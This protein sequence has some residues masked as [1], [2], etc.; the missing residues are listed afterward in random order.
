M[1]AA[2]ISR[3][4]GRSAAGRL[5]I[6]MEGAVDGVPL[7]IAGTTGGSGALLADTGPWPISLRATLDKLPATVDGT[8][9][10]P[11]SGKGL[12]LDITLAADRF[13]DL[14]RL[15]GTELRADGAFKLSGH[16]SDADGSF[17]LERLAAQLGT[18]DLAGRLEMT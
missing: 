8:I 2:P 15:V 18:S 12:G 4:R 14:G 3:W 17:V 1:A 11:R 13:A 6:A 7:S 9:A 5:D 10:Q 16:L